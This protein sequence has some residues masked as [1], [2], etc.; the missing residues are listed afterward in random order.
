MVNSITIITIG[1]ACCGMVLLLILI[2]RIITINKANQLK[3]YRRKNEGLADLLN[4]ASVIDDGVILCK[5]GSL[6][7]AWMFFGEDYDTI[8]D[9]QKEYISLRL[10][11]CIA[12]L[13]SGWMLHIDAIRIAAPSYSAKGLSCFPDKISAAIDEE[14]RRYFEKNGNVFETAHVLTATFYPP[15]LAQAKFVDFLFDDQGQRVT[16]QSRSFGILADFKKKIADMESS[17]SSVLKLVRLGSHKE[18][19]ENGNTL[20]YDAFLRYIQYCLTGLE[21]PVILPKNPSYIDAFIGGQELWGGTIPKIGKNFV[22]IVAIDGFPLESYPGMLSAI[23]DIPVSCRFSSRFIFMDQHQAEAALQKQKKKWQQKQR[24]ILDQVLNRPVTA[25]RLNQDAVAMV[26]DAN[27]ALQEINEGIVAYGYYTPVIVLMDESRPRLEESSRNLAKLVNNLGFTAR[28]ETVN[29]LD[30]FFGSLP[31]HG[32]E[33]VRRPFINTMNFTD[34]LPT[35][36]IWTG[37]NYA[38]CPFYPPNSPPLMHCVTKGSAPYRYNTHVRDVGHTLIVGATGAGKSTLLAIM[39]A[40]ACRYKDATITVFD[41]GASMYPLARACGGNFYD[42]GG[43]NV[44]LS[45]APL[46]HLATDQDRAWVLEWIEKI[47]KLNGVTSSPSLRNEISAAIISL[48]KINSGNICLTDFIGQVQSNTVREVLQQYDSGGLMGNM[49]SA[50][51]D[52]LTMTRFNVFEIEHLMQLGE[53]WSLPVLDYLFRRVECANKG[54]PSWLFLD[55]AWLMLGHKAFAAKIREWLKVFRKANCA[56]V[57]AT[58]NLMDFANSSIF[59]DIVDS[60]ASKVFLPN[61]FARNEDIA[62]VYKRM[63]L[64]EQQI[65]IVAT[66]VPKRHYYHMTD[67]GSRLFDLALG[68]IALAFVGST[69]KDSLT[70]IRKLESIHGDKWPNIWVNEKTGLNL[71]ITRDDSEKKAK[72]GF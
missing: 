20:T 52:G 49:L 63:N 14:R 68:P 70:R 64:N 38:P 32:V 35:S 1:I 59:T 53:K 7:A 19:T 6:M 2:S 65:N 31:G 30:A 26:A 41:K 28:I 46:Q 71:M 12:A 13:G 40:Q 72:T 8:V 24:G 34:L 60:T 66:S 16:P 25:D 61:I 27:N 4:Y 50:E 48:A 29:T 3:I 47:L 45:F 62:A 15:V 56:V 43:E 58:Q 9:Q 39:A 5:N 22:Q 57:M 23:A 44:S 33:N 21:H 42:I 10:N 55:E 37:Q 67:L 69:D 11:Q 51:K 17:F 18:I 54:Q 36:S